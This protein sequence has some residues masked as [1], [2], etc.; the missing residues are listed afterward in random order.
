[1]ARQSP[2]PASNILA[3]ALVAGFGLEVAGHNAPEGMGVVVLYVP[4][5]KVE[6]Q[7]PLAIQE[8]LGLPWYSSGCPPIWF[9]EV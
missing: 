1:M 2:N 9:D 5:E 8:D 3:N 7:M 6:S 4:L